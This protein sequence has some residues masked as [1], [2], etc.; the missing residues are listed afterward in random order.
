MS[1]QHQQAVP[2]WLAEDEPFD[3]DQS[4]AQVASVLAILDELSPEPDRDRAQRHVLE[5]GCG[6]GR[7]LIPVAASGHHVVGV[8]F[9]AEAVERC[10][11]RSH[12]YRSRVQLVH[13]DFRRDD[14]PQAD[15]KE[16]SAGGG[17]D[18]VLLL[19]NTLMTLTEVDEAIALFS[20][21]ADN[22]APHGVFIID[23]MAGCFWPELTEGNWQSG[24]SEDSSMQLVWHPRDTLFTIRLGDQV[25]PDAWE[26][27]PSDRVF[28]LWTAALL[29]MVAKQAGLSEPQTADEFVLAVMHRV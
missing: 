7:V 12:A 25:D 16:G 24:L 21:A 17:Y 20:R 13:A 6:G 29:A 23:D 9:N 28:R 18:A 3:V 11:R 19:G 8:D 27:K 2:P 5:L 14:W 15:A 10:R 22:L 4:R 26:L 1:D